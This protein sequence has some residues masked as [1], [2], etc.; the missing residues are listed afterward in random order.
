[1]VLHRTENQLPQSLKFTTEQRCC[2]SEDM[3]GHLQV[4]KLMEGK[5]YYFRVIAEN[6]VGM[7]DAIETTKSVK[8]KSA[9]STLPSLSRPNGQH[10]LVTF[11]VPLRVSRGEQTHIL[12]AENSHH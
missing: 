1:M 3:C 4:G 9:F 7:G 2:Y 8:I 10:T 12:A 11:A 6:E 5:E